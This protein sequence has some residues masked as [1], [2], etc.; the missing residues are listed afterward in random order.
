MRIEQWTFL[1]FVRRSSVGG[2]ITL[3]SDGTSLAL[4]GDTASPGAS[5]YYGTDSG[6]TKGYYAF[7]GGGGPGYTDEEAR[8]A[9]GA[10]LTD[11]ATID[12]TYDDAG[13][14]I[15]AIVADDSITYAKL[16]NISA[17]SRLLGRITGGA[18][19]AEELT[20]TQVTTLLDAFTSVLKGLVPASGGGTTNF[21]RAD[22][23]FA[24]P[25]S[26]GTAMSFG[27]ATLTFGAAPGTN[28]VTT[29]VTGLTGIL[30]GSNVSAWIMGESTAD[31][32]AYEHMFVPLR[33]V[34]GN[35]VAGTGFDITAV[36][37]LRLT[38]T[39]K[40]RWMGDF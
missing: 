25:P 9:V 7:G 14:T 4:D 8:D 1:N 18:G 35:I 5:K 3:S 15:T 24:A 26:G 17:T 30:S 29:T 16:Q 31:H 12:F 13:N 34:C 27:E 40:C 28:F 19:N 39:F 20:G 37:D 10:M 38:G 33:L 11:S 32:N 23:T 36:T 6:G 2:S 21:L 22:G